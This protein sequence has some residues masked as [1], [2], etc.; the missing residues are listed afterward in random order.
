M[1]STSGAAGLHTP[2]M[3]LPSSTGLGCTDEGLPNGELTNQDG[4]DR[5]EISP[6]FLF[7][8]FFD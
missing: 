8:V 7:H 4:N 6:S 5:K 3:C 2:A 1:F